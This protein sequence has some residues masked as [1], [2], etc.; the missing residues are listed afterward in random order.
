MFI[1]VDKLKMITT[2]N[3]ITCTALFATCCICMACNSHVHKKINK[4]FYYWKTNFDISRF[5]QRKLDSFHC[6]TLYLRFFDIDWSPEINGP[7]PVAINRFVRPLQNGFSCVPVV[8]ITQDAVNKTPAND[9]ENLAS[10][11]TNLLYEKCVQSKI[12]PAEIQIDCDWTAH[13]KDKY[14]LLL[15]LCKKQRFFKGKT[16]SCTIRLH[17]AHSPQV[18]GIPPVDRGLLMCYNMGNLKLAG[19]N[20]SILDIAVSERYLDNLQDYPLPLDIALPLFSWSLLYDNEN[21]FTGILRDVRESDLQNNAIFGTR[22]KNI[23]TI[24]KDTLWNGY[25]LRKNETIRYESCNTADLYKLTDFVAT[26]MNG[27]SFSLI[28]YHCDSTVLSKYTNDELEKIY[29]LFN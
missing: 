27:P 16:L 23:Y 2:S 10:H 6:K 22:G 1:C 11:L 25:N 28:F 8:F 20:N 9:M 13:N 3:F 21:R 24:N 17:Q 4:A 15:K 5:E 18:N 14:F 26:K 7:K 19:G 29:H 12:T